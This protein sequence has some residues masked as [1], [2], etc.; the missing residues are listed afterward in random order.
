V[1]PVRVYLQRYDAPGQRR[2]AG[3]GGAVGESEPSGAWQRLIAALMLSTIGGSGFWSVVVALPAIGTAFAVDRADG[4]LAYAAP[5]VG[6]SAG[7]LVGA[8]MAGEIFDVT[9]SYRDAFLDAPYGMPST[10]RS[11]RGCCGG[12]C[13]GR[14]HR[15]RPRRQP[16]DR[17]DR[18]R[19]VTERPSSRTLLGQRQCRRQT[20]FER[21]PLTA[22]GGGERSRRRS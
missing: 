13:A 20:F 19:A 10:S 8:E 4:L 12:R 5:M 3:H 16:C 22:P 21:C 18:R 6:C 1:R 7:T 11:S 9:G 15:S 14:R 2:R 17:T